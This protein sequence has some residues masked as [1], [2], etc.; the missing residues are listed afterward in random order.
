MQNIQRPQ[1]TLKVLF[2]AA[3]DVAGMVAFA[4]GAMWLA[5]K[6]ALFIE[7]FPTSTSEAVIAT[8]GG[9]LLMLWAAAQILRELMTRPANDA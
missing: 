2:Y 9:L 6:Q 3:F 7:G 5:R 1:L 8:I 4:T